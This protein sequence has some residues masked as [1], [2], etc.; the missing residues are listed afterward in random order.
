MSGN[1]PCPGP[2]TST[3]TLKGL[4]S[5]EGGKGRIVNLLAKQCRKLTVMAKQKQIEANPFG[6]PTC[7]FV[8]KTALRIDSRLTLP[9][10]HLPALSGLKREGDSAQHLVARLI[11]EQ[12]IC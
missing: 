5:N 2:P 9:K 8:G 3:V 10:F 1:H 6:H 12:C 7:R 11:N 4:T